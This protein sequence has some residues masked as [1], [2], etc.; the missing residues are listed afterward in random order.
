MYN[1]IKRLKNVREASTERS[2]ALFELLV[3]EAHAD[4]IESALQVLHENF[5]VA[6]VVIQTDRFQ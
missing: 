1:I 5:A 6:I 4:L 2:S 3:G